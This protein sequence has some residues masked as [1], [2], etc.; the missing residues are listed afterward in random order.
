MSI[1]SV[2]AAVLLARLAVPLEA[3]GY[4]A[5]RHKTESILIIE[6]PAIAALARVAISVLDSPAEELHLVLLDAAYDLD[7]DDDLVDKVEAALPI[8]TRYLP[9]GHLERDL[10]GT[11]HARW[12]LA[13]DASQGLDTDVVVTSIVMFDLIQQHFGDYLEMVCDGDVPPE[14]LEELIAAAGDVAEDEDD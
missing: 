11:L 13:A 6:R 2:R 4:T 12:T 14:D 3:L 10:D 9:V 1:E 5:V 7:P 8:I